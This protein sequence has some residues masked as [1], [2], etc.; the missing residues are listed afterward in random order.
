M[1]TIADDGVGY[2]E[3]RSSKRHGVGLVRRLMEQI[4]GAVSVSSNQGTLWT[5]AFPVSGAVELGQAS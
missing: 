5:L 2:V 3:A 1:L 4:G